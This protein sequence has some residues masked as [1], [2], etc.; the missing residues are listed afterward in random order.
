MDGDEKE[1]IPLFKSYRQ[2]GFAVFLLGLLFSL[3]S[4]WLLY[5]VG[6]QE[7]APLAKFLV[8][9][10]AIP[11]TAMFIGLLEWVTGQPFSR[12][13]TQWDALAGWQR[14]VLGI[15]IIIGFIGLIMAL[16]AVFLTP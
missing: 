3:P 16:A 12:F 9:L 1:R 5:Y 15:A 2:R 4:I 10:V 7:Y 6:E 8:W 13:S 14:G 11:V